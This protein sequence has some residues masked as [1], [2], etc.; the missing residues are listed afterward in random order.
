[1][2]REQNFDEVKIFELSSFL[3]ICV[4]RSLS[5]QND[6]YK[7]MFWFKKK[8]VVQETN[9]NLIIKPMGIPNEIEKNYFWQKLNWKKNPLFIFDVDTTILCILYRKITK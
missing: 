3:S 5:T 6:L 4:E 8:F 9:I 7:I 1:M 2:F